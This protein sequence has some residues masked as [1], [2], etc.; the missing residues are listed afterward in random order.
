ME[1]TMFD[2][3][4]TIFLQL[5]FFMNTVCIDWINKQIKKIPNMSSPYIT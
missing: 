1:K 5:K 3:L 4:K 2:L